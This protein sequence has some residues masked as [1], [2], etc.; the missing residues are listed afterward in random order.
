MSK[1]QMTFKRAGKAIG[2]GKLTHAFRD[3]RMVGTIVETLGLFIV[4]ETGHAFVVC[5]SM[6]EAKQQFE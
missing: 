3:G 5:K 6:L 2:G 1:A 4:Q